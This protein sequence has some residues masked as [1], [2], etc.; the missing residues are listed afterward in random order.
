VVVRVFA[1]NLNFFIL[2]YFWIDVL[3]LKIN[4]LK[5]YYFNTFSS[6]K[7]FEK[8]LLPQKYQTLPK[9]LV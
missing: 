5:K 6:K 8:Q 7:Y 1:K 9:V 4:F 2:K 3:M